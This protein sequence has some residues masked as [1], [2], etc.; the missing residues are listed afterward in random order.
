M[1]DRVITPHNDQKPNSKMKP[2]W[3][4][5]MH[6]LEALKDPWGELAV[7]S[8]ANVTGLSGDVQMT[9]K[10]YLPIY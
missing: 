5:I 1:E 9:L 7:V 3:P 2:V 8:F 6:A 10:R 4:R